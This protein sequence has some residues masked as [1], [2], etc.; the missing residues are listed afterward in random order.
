MP[1]RNVTQK[2]AE[3]RWIEANTFS[4]ILFAVSQVLRIYARVQ[5]GASS[6]KLILR[7]YVITC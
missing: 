5:N 7:C 4:F 3:N 6:G 1:Y 2:Y